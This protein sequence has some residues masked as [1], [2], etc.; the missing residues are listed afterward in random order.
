MFESQESLH[1]WWELEY[2]S[3]KLCILDAHINRVPSEFKLATKNGT[4]V[5]NDIHEDWREDVLS[6]SVSHNTLK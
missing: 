5:A 2:I 3:F 6:C 4:D 1:L